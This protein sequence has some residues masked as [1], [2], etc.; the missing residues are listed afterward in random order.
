MWHRILEALHHMRANEMSLTSAA[1]ESGTTPRTMKK[2]LGRTLE[3][4]ESGYYEAK[5][6]DRLLRRLRF[7]T[8][9][10][11]I[12]ID[13]RSYHTAEK[14]ARYWNAVDAFLRTGK[15]TDLV[16]FRGKGI[17]I[18]SRLYLYVTEPRVLRRLALAG[19][20]RFED[21]YDL[22]AE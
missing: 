18:G 20:V 8:P 21:L 22:T 14:I 5:P 7:L 3:K 13:T 9:D 6:T 12:T 15:T 10:G 1:R 4:S 16:D 11:Q 19:E 2:H 17:R